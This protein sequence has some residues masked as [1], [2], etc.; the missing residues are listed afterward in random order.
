LELGAE[1]I[2]PL[3]QHS[4]AIQRTTNTKPDQAPRSSLTRSETGLFLLSVSK[5]K[6][7]E[8]GKSNHPVKK[9]KGGDRKVFIFLSLWC[10]HICN[11]ADEDV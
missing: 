7:K 4:N 8:A 1:H 5:G 6:K 10:G 11:T 9:K 2:T 3:Q